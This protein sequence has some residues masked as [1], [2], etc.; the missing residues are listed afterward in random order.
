MSGPIFKR[1]L[2]ILVSFALVLGVVPSLAATNCCDPAS[3]AMQMSIGAQKAD[4]D[5]HQNVP[6][7][8]PADA[9]AAM[10]V[11]MANVALIAPEVAVFGP[12][13][14]GEPSWSNAK[15]LSGIS[16]PPALPPPITRA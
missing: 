9:C 6:H 16:D 11:S 7:K 14:I 13:T 2:P 5:H 1:L 8:M 12:M 15:H 4:M 10:C 3:M